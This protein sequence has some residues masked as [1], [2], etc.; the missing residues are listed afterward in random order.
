[1]TTSPK[2]LVEI[3]LRHANRNI[4][5]D[6]DGEMCPIGEDD[7]PAY[8][9]PH[10]WSSDECNLCDQPRFT[11]PYRSVYLA[12]VATDVEI[13]LETIRELLDAN[14]RLREAVKELVQ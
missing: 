2:V 5:V 1:M 3:E 4:V 13:L 8:S 10:L 7:H 9:L 6:H 11:Y 12:H 14:D